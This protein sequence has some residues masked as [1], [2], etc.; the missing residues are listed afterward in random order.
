MTK[1]LTSF[2]PFVG[3]AGEIQTRARRNWEALGL[4]VVEVPG[5]LRSA[6]P[7]QVGPPEFG[8]V[9]ARVEKGEVVIYANGDILFERGL[10]EAIKAAPEG[11]F[12]MIGRRWDEGKV[13]RPSGMDYF[14]FRGGM[15][16][17]LP[18]T[19]VGRAYYDC[20]L[21]NWCLKRGIK[22]ID[23]SGVVKAVHQTHDYGHVEGGRAAVFGGEDALENKRNNGMKDFG[24]HLAD[25]THEMRWSN[26]VE[27]EIVEKKVGWMRKHGWWKLWNLVTRGGLYYRGLERWQEAMWINRSIVEKCTP[28]NNVVARPRKLAAEFDLVK[29]S[30]RNFFRV[31]R[32]VTGF[33]FPCMAL[34]LL[35]HWTGGKWTCC[36]WDPPV[37]W[38]RDEH[39][40]FTKIVDWVFRFFIKRADKI[41]LNIH[42]GLLD[43]LELRGGGGEKRWS[44]E[45]EGERG[46]L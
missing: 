12:L 13:H 19:I 20:A 36:I 29:P 7:R 10:K 11:D 1:I 38:V 26:E 31:P 34:G 18:R 46:R 2:K 37:L 17:D 30:V 9:R 22:V 4:E 24:P 42:P 44:K 43:E 35:K 15:F 27:V 33:D 16:E 39:P 3:R 32:V 5:R 45:V 25:A 23:V 6:T 28:N 40:Q 14:I 41:I 8:E 21:V